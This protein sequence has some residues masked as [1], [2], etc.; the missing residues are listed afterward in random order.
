MRHKDKKPKADFD[1]KG[2]Y[3]VIRHPSKKRN[4]DEGSS[5]GPSVE[6]SPENSTDRM[7]GLDSQKLYQQTYQTYGYTPQMPPDA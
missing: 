3:R 7:N 4:L 5:R 6:Q 2:S 1:R